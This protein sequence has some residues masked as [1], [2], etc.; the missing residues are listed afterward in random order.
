MQRKQVEIEM[1]D[2]TKQA[3]SMRQITRGERKKLT[4]EVMP[5]EFKANDAE[6]I[7]VKTDKWEDYREKLVMTCIESPATL[8]TS[9]GI[10]ILLDSEF[11]KLFVVAGELNP[12]APS[13]VTEKK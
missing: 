7:Q 13:E 12:Q 11:N 1:A 4:V 6:S 5:P 3:V 10:S 2:G 9:E 8:K